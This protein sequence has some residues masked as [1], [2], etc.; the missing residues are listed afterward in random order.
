MTLSEATF[1]FHKEYLTILFE[2][3]IKENK[4]QE[5]IENSLE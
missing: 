1:V 3:N 5:F 2:L 4:K